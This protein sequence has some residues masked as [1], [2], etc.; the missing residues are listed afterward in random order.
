M[1]RVGV[2]SD[3]HGLLRDQ[4]ITALADSDL[5]LHAGDIGR[6]DVIAR[7]EQIAPVVAVRGN[8]DRDDWALAYPEF[9]VARVDDVVFYLTHRLRDLQLDPAI[10]G[11]RIVVTG[12]SHKPEIR[13]RDGVTYLNP[14]SAGP[15]RFSLPVCLAQVEVEGT[16]A[17]ADLVYLEV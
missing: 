14:G 13:Y 16:Q 11:Y 4:A 6:D 5:I 12:H 3:T 17:K 7:L 15:R 8:V 10:E 1:P 2:I 9:E